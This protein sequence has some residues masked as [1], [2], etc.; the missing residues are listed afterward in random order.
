MGFSVAGL[1]GPARWHRGDACR[2][3]VPAV[4]LIML[5]T[6]QC[7]RAQDSC[8]DPSTL[9]ATTVGISRHFTDEERPRS[10]LDGYRAT[11]WFFRSA[12]YL[13][14]IAHFVDVAP[15]LPKGEWRTVD[16]R[17]QDLTVHVKARLLTVVKGLPEGLALLELQEPFPDAKPLR[18]R[19][20]PLSRNEP[21]L[22]VAYLDDLRFAKGRFS[23][24]M[25]NRD[26]SSDDAFAKVPP[27]SGLF[28]MWDIEERKNDRYVLDH[29][30]S[31]A[32]IVDCD[33]NV[34]AVASS[35]LMQGSLFFGGQKFRLTTPWGM[36]NNTATLI[37]PLF[38][39]ELSR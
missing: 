15:V 35:I 10:P 13:V 37:Q 32:P 14:S 9:V 30:A 21:V 4:T 34:A 12:R 22:S 26:D 5:V 6:T 18:L 27:G 20:K 19:E 16:V 24:L 7:A 23:E 2:L 17:Q 1:L 11:A 25:G 28:E 29:G 39:V 3:T 8:I 36:A 38:G 31:G 33:G